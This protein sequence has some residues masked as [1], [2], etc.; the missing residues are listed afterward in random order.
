MLLIYGN[1]TEWEQ[2]SDGKECHGIRRRALSADRA[3]KRGGQADARR[4]P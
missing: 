4:E 2:R 3:V 1:D